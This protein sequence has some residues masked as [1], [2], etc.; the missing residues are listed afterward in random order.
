MKRGIVHKKCVSGFPVLTEAFPMISCEQDDRLL[1]KPV[2]VQISEQLADYRIRISDF[3]HIR[4]AWVELIEFRRWFV[5]TMR[6]VKMRPKKKALF[7]VLIQP[8]RGQVVNV[9]R[10]SFDA[11]KADSIFF[12]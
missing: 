12:A 7:S 6:I 9:V 10:F 11:G 4:T 2:S 5:W 8:V 3:T 1:S